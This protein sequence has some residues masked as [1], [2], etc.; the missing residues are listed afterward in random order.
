LFLPLG[1]AVLWDLSRRKVDD[2]AGLSK[3]LSIDSIGTIPR[4]TWDFTQEPTS[5]RNQIKHF[6]LMESVSSV[7]TMMLHRSEHK[8]MQVFMITSAVAG[9][10]K[11]SLSCLLSRSLSQ[12]GK[13]VILV[14][15]DLRRPTVHRFFG[16][17]DGSGVTEILAGERSLVE[18]VQEVE[19]HGLNVL[20]AG[21]AKVN[22]QRMIT[23]GTVA[24]FFEQLRREYD[25][26]VVDT[27]PVL[28]VVD[29]RLISKYSD[30]VVFM[31][32]R[33]YSRFPQAARAIEILK[34]FGVNL[35]GALLI[36]YDQEHYGYRGYHGYDGYSSYYAKPSA[37]L[38]DSSKLGS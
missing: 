11:S 19:S 29:T 31:L 17:S 4:A 22:L 33:D 20:V 30:G 24:K 18:C 5:Q 6:R 13:R 14:D 7:A 10:G 16:L 1:L 28:P 34:S 23:D 21:Q 9:E 38:P 3:A 15:F 27:C 35:L 2:I 32:L 8:K 25:I 26:V 12:F 37:R 36:G